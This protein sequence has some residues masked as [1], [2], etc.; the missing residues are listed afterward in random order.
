[1]IYQ[2][3][4]STYQGI[5]I[6]LPIGIV[7]LS[8]ICVYLIASVGYKKGREDIYLNSFDKIPTEIA[9]FI[10]GILYIIMAYFAMRIAQSIINNLEQFA[11]LALIGAIPAYLVTIL[12]FVTFV[13]RIK[14]HTLLRNSICYRIIIKIIEFIKNMKI[15]FRTA[16][17]YFMF[18]FITTILILERDRGWN[19]LLLIGMWIVCGIYILNRVIEYYKIRDF[20]QHLYEGNE[21]KPLNEVEFKGE[22]KKLVLKLNDIASGFSNAIEKGI[23][24]ERLKTELITNVSH[25]IKTPLTSIINYVDLLKK[26]NLEN[27]K[28]KEYLEVLDKKS[29]RLKKLTEDLVEASKASSGNIK[30]NMEN[31][32]MKELIAQEIGEFDEK[33]KEKGLQIIKNFT[34]KDI[35]IYADGKYMSRILDNLFSNIA[36]YALPNSRVYIDANM[37][38]DGIEIMFKNISANQL[39][40]TAN[41]LMERFVRGDV[42]RSTEGSG[43]GLSIA[44]SLTKLQGGS[45]DI[46]LDGDLF[47]VVIKFK[48]IY[49][50][51]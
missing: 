44:E 48:K 38:T 39:N 25:D 18:G 9:I 5:I 16:I 13:R 3:A 45:F 20:I 1:M 36:K 34:E 33:F 23:Q 40:I 50:N 32:N 30:L 2:I 26:E 35:L 10:I 8:L 12:A 29:Q 27:D 47:K 43:L 28:A 24:S 49:Q 31:L 6:Y 17:L 4:K 37:T 19:L 14:S 22:F 41:E 21:V 46:Y 7:G 42:A 51:H 11:I 15:T